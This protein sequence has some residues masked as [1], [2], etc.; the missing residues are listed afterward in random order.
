MTEVTHDTAVRL[1]IGCGEHPRPGYVHC[2]VRPL[3]GVDHVCPAWDV[4]VAAGS[5]AEIYSRHMLEHLRLPDAQRTVRHWFALLRLGGC[6][7]LCVPD[8]A[9]HLEQLNTPGDSPHV[10]PGK[11]VSN[12]M[13]AMA[14]LYGWQEHPDDVHRWAYTFETLGELLLEAGF[15]DVTRVEDDSLSGPLN[16][17]V[18]AV[19]RL[20]ANGETR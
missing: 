20:D 7:D 14:G 3:A 6:V 19:K 16:L 2:D 12:R 15:D 10:W 11:I 9:R 17:R 1:E 13:H 18:V 4:P 5:V 8:L